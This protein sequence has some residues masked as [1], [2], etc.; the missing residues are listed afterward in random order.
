M[1]GKG[2]GIDSDCLDGEVCVVRKAKQDAG[3]PE[4]DII[5]A[6][7]LFGKYLGP[8][9]YYMLMQWL[10]LLMPSQNDKT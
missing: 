4:P 3:V 1:F 9:Y 2:S 7:P 10:K 6:S 5:D 8:N